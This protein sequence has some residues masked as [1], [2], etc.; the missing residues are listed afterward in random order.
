MYDLGHLV[1]EVFSKFAMVML[2]FCLSIVF[3]VSE[4]TNKTYVVNSGDNTVSVIDGFNDKKESKDMRVKESPTEIAF[5]PT[6]R[7]YYV[8][9][10]DTVSV[11]NGFND[12]IAAGVT[13]NVSPGN[14]GSIVC[15]CLSCSCSS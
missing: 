6:T 4:R 5:N 13:F 3:A 1:S 14:L 2:L 9:N 11:I 12:R 10:S 7:M 15:S 8:M